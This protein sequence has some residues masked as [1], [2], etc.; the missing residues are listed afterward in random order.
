[1]KRALDHGR[2]TSVILTICSPSAKNMYLFR[3]L[4]SQGKIGI[5]LNQSLMM[6]K[7]FKKK[8]SR[9]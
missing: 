7:M 1:M 6:K 2:K 8:K 5:G 4:L 3:V 9:M